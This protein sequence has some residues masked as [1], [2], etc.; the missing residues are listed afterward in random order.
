MDKTISEQ[1][2]SKIEKGT[3]WADYTIFA[4]LFFL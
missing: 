2:F 1:F 4:E 3:N